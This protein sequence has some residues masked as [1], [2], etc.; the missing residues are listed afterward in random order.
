[1]G[2]KEIYSTVRLLVRL[3]QERK[4]SYVLR[5]F[6][7]VNPQGR[8]DQPFLS[9]KPTR[10]THSAA[11]LLTCTMIRDGERRPTRHGYRVQRLIL[12]QYPLLRFSS[13]GLVSQQ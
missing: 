2:L 13:I 10:G 11:R 8:F 5:E 7:H 4:N 12:L 9:R 3:L 1:M 6:I